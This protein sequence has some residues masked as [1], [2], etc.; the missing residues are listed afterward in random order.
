MGQVVFIG[1]GSGGGGGDGGGSPPVS[2]V[3]GRMGTIWSSFGDY[4]ASLV[5][6]DSN[7]EGFSVAEAL[8]TLGSGGYSG[9]ITAAQI[10]AGAGTVTIYHELNTP[11]PVVQVYGDDNT[12][13]GYNEVLI[14]AAG[15]NA[16]TVTFLGGSP[17]NFAFSAPARIVALK[18][19]TLQAP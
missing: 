9:D 10:T 3:F 7:V 12:L 5:N 4:D 2:S 8:N 16:V 18:P 6:N 14:R 1:F 11:Y 19:I 17:Q 15:L 13:L